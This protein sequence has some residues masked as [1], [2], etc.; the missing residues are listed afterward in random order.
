MNIRNLLTLLLLLVGM[1]VSASVESGYYYIKSYNGKYMTEN[2]SNHTLVCSEKV[3]P[4]YY[5][6]VWYLSVSGS[7]VTFKN[8][9]DTTYAAGA[10]HRERKESGHSLNVIN[11]ES[12]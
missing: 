3:T 2:T 7:D 4:A 8:A 6:Q 5:A 11:T 9:G 10:L 1:A 12:I